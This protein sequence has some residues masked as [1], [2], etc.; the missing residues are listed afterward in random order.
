MS[1]PLQPAEGRPHDRPDRRLQVASLDFRNVLSFAFRML[2]FGFVRPAGALLRLRRDT[3][4]LVRPD[5]TNWQHAA[6]R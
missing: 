4:R 3:L 6:R 5:G 1:A 2:F